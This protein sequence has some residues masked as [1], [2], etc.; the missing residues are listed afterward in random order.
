[1][2]FTIIRAIAFAVAL[3]LHQKSWD[4]GVFPLMS[5]ELEASRIFSMGRNP[6]IL[7]QRFHEKQH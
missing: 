2:P 1:M 7:S 3:F 4:W 6:E 5:G